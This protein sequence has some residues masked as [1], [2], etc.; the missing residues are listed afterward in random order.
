M[1]VLYAVK[2]AIERRFASLSRQRQQ[3]IQVNIIFCRRIRDDSLMRGGHA[4]LIYYTSVYIVH[5]NPCHSRET[6]NFRDRA[7]PSR[8]ARKK[9]PVHGPAR[10]ERLQ[11]RVSPLNNVCHHLYVPEPSD[12]FRPPPGVSCCTRCYV[13]F[14][15]DR[16]K[17]V[18]PHS[19]SETRRQLSLSS[20]F[21]VNPHRL[22]VCRSNP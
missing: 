1:R 17:S 19:K 6:Q 13:C 15:E 8:I 20:P 3:I 10:P 9:Q 11:Y 7:M 16:D 2:D 12:C 14:S 21:R 4:R 22:G 5:R 18:A